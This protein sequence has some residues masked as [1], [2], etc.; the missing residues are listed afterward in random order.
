VS[1]RLIQCTWMSSVPTARL[2]VLSP[3][4]PRVVLLLL[5]NTCPAPAE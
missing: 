1:S 4:V 5:P 2:Y 3:R